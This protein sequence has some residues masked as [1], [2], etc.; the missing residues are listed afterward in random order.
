MTGKEI[1]RY[2]GSLGGSTAFVRPERE[3]DLRRSSSAGCFGSRGG[4]VPAVS[5]PYI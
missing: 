3:I 2:S 5:F 4:A 1:L